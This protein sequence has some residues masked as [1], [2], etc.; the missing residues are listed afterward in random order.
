MGS[1]SL[2]VICLHV[3]LSLVEADVESAGAR[4]VNVPVR[5]SELRLV[6]LL[7][8]VKFGGSTCNGTMK[9]EIRRPAWWRVHLPAMSLVLRL[10][11]VLR[12]VP[13]RE[14]VTLTWS[15]LLFTVERDMRSAR[16]GI[17]KSPVRAR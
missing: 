9:L 17:A 5:V 13:K 8:A 1:G 10:L 11:L 2:D 15:Y 3:G 4:S 16:L 6:A 14:V 7:G 12:M